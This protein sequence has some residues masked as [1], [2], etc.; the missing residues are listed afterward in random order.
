[1][2]KPRKSFKDRI[3]KFLLRSAS[4][5]TTPSS[6]P[7]KRLPRNPQPD[8]KPSPNTTGKLDRH[9]SFPSHSDRPIIQITIDC[10]GRRSV[11]AAAPSVKCK[12]KKEKRLTETGFLYVSGDCE[13]R[14]CPP[15]S[16]YS[17]S[18]CVKKHQYLSK[19]ERKD[20]NFTNKLFYNGYT[21]SSSSNSIGS[22]NDNEPEFFSSDKEKQELISS[23]SFSFSSES[24]EFY[25][26]KNNYTRENRCVKEGIEKVQVEEE[27]ESGFAVVKRSIDPYKDFRNSMVEMILE[28]RI[29]GADDM[30][31]LLESYLELNSSEHHPT[32][33]SAFA[34]VWD[35]IFPKS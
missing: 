18:N 14:T 2:E 25:R 7:F 10:A 4:S 17:P 1:M 20:K 24:S 27:E 29:N 12:K 5:N 23:R 8:P 3:S 33:V 11:D 30:R 13:G 19:S 15:T 35:S 22:E 32:I 34:D 6:R 31:R 9:I 28:R 26:R 21:F 16:P